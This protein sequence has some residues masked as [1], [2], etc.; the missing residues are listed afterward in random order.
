V[1][2][3]L[4]EPSIRL[5]GPNRH[6]G[7]AISTSARSQSNTAAQHL[8]GF[9]NSLWNNAG[10]L[11]E[12]HQT[13]LAWIAKHNHRLSRAYLLKGLLRPVFQHR[14]DNTGP[15]SGEVRKS[16]R[17]PADPLPGGVEATRPKQ[18]LVLERPKAIGACRSGD[19]IVAL[20]PARG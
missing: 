7:P 14:G 11:T 12:R 1:A 8:K 19:S 16:S 5:S 4:D 13:Q 18:H 2:T 3:V 6:S 17:R 9:R 20:C 15:T 10:T